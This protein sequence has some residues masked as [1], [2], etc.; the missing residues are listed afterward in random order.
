LSTTSA[1]GGS[2]SC[3][4][5][6]VLPSAFGYCSAAGPGSGHKGCRVVSAHPRVHVMHL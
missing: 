2:T 6:T 5:L 3:S 1:L 4:S